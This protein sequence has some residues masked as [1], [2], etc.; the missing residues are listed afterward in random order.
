M[1]LPGVPLLLL[2]PSWEGAPGIATLLLAFAMTGFFWML[3]EGQ[4]PPHS[5]ASWGLKLAR[6]L[7]FWGILLSVL[8]WNLPIIFRTKTYSGFDYE[9]LLTFVFSLFAGLVLSFVLASYSFFFIKNIKP[10]T[11]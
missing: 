7:V 8:L 9:L 4:T 10:S 3:F 6:G 5:P 11:R 2:R 1:L